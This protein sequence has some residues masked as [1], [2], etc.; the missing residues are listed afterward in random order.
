MSPSRCGG[1]ASPLAGGSEI[2]GLGGGGGFAVR[3]LGV[4]A[5][6]PRKHE[7]LLGSPSSDNGHT[8]WYRVFH[9]F[10]LGAYQTP[11]PVEGRKTT[12]LCHGPRT[13]GL[14]AVHLIPGLTKSIALVF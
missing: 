14:A 13:F 3:G 1:F 10:V 6:P 11:H 7:T 5:D 9:L 12:L 8:S 2:V 4:P